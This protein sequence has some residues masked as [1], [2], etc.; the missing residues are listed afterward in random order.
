MDDS[1]EIS[2]SRN[3]I[4]LA[5]VHRNELGMCSHEFCLE[6][7]DESNND[8]LC[9]EHSIISY[10]SI[11]LSSESDQQTIMSESHIE[12]TPGSSQD[13]MT[14]FECFEK[15][16][17]KNPMGKDERSI[18]NIG[19]IIETKYSSL[20]DFEISK[21]LSDFEKI[22]EKLR[23]STNSGIRSEKENSADANNA[24]ISKQENDPPKN[25]PS[26]N[27][28]M[29]E[30]N[31]EKKL[32]I[33]KH[34][35]IFKMSAEVTQSNGNE[36]NSIITII[37]KS[38]VE[39][40]SDQSLLYSSTAFGSVE[41]EKVIHDMNEKNVI[42]CGDDK[43]IHFAHI[44]KKG[45]KES[46][47]FHEIDTRMHQ[48]DD[49]VKKQQ[50]KI[51]NEKV[52]LAKKSSSFKMSSTVTL[53]TSEFKDDFVLQKSRSTEHLY[54]NKTKNDKALEEF[55]TKAN[56]IKSYWSNI[57]Y[58]EEDF[59]NNSNIC[60][61][62]PKKVI[63]KNETISQAN[64]KLSPDKN[65][66]TE[67][68]DETVVDISASEKFKEID[69]DHVRYSVLKS[70]MLD[71]NLLL[72]NPKTKS[73]DN[74]MQYLQNYSFQELLIDNNVVIIEP[75]R[76]KFEKSSENL[77]MGKLSDIS[78]LGS[79]NM[80]KNFF[81]QP[82]CVNKEMNEEE[83]PEPDTVRNVRKFFED[84]LKYEDRGGCK[85]RLNSK[86]KAFS[87]ESFEWDLQSV[88]SGV[89]SAADLNFSYE[90]LSTDVKDKLKLHERKSSVDVTK[91]AGDIV[92]LE[93][94]YC[95]DHVDV[96][97]IN[98]LIKFEKGK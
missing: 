92:S 65:L 72:K 63:L 93:E 21:L 51:S 73:Y 66:L 33:P 82:I 29:Q 5:D 40:S 14:E 10:N 30:D 27:L 47:T 2:E 70:K 28:K 24:M 62:T 52:K 36:H 48:I 13:A 86:L 67:S 11:Y 34:C 74:L 95:S 7:N 89:S 15:I 59:S 20:P 68:A 78:K 45:F 55:L 8:R 69:F 38:I 76:T 83:L 37:P 18:K 88:S 77:I 46:A 17:M 6:K 61:K 43:S 25:D 98:G 26:I 54:S 75:V 50:V 35:H 31:L 39:S 4:S 1:R 3:F 71:R 84:S 87:S 81:Y 80:N 64:E 85:K 44:E 9:S 91:I 79:G 53:K 22:D 49:R 60:H 96:A 12:N 19:N 23:S 42:A 56:S 57:F 97:Q 32:K 58:P 94:K 90:Y 16:N 41:S